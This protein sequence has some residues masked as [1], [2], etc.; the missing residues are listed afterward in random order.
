MTRIAFFPTIERHGGGIFQY[1]ATMVRALQEIAADEP[2]LEVLAL[3]PQWGSPAT[4]LALP[5]RWRVVPLADPHAGG[6]SRLRRLAG[7]GPHREMW[8]ALRRWLSR[9]RPSDAPASGLDPIRYRPDMQEWWRRQGIQLVIYPQP[10]ALAFEVGIPYIMAV[11]DLQHRLQPEFPEV[12]A[13]GEWGRREYIM[14]NGVRHATTVLVDSQ[15]GKEQVLFFYGSYGVTADRVQVLPFLPAITL[16]R[17]LSVKTQQEIRSRCAI[18][19]RYVFYPAQFWPH[20]NHARIIAALERLR[21]VNGVKVPAVF[22][23]SSAGH[24]REGHSQLL[25]SMAKDCGVEDQITVL[26]YVPDDHL[27]AL[28]SGAVALVMPTFFGPT[29]IP[30]L[31]AWALGCPVLT[32]DIPGIREQAGDA[33]LLVD[34]R[35]AEAL[36][37]AILRLWTSEELRKDLIERGKRTLSS[38][39]P[40][41][42]RKRLREILADAEARSGPR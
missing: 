10:N 6:L 30:V 2:E 33:A 8:R 22:C 29:N 41:H 26:G 14:R 20:K 11:H 16:P 32:S 7:E 24:V 38:Y 9:H 39:T 12:S 23:G 15:L 25:A 37:D 4:D 42:Y 34:P 5:A 36:A 3:L 40:E 18:P 28:Y 1:S 17:D 19:E 13:D 21:R 31:E 27:S 35:S